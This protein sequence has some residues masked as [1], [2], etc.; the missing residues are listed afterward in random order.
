MTRRVLCTQKDA[1]RVLMVRM[2]ASAR[3]VAY[4]VTHVPDAQNAMDFPRLE[5]LL[6]LLWQV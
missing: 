6:E 4:L 5:K 1:T 2:C 3:L